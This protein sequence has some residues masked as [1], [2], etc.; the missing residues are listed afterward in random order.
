[1]LYSAIQACLPFANAEFTGTSREGQAVCY[2]SF[3]CSIEKQTGLSL[4][5]GGWGEVARSDSLIMVPNITEIHLDISK[6]KI[7][8]DN[9]L[10]FID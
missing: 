7:V 8:I 5:A 6:N 9:N 3:T 2:T 10:L 1:M 4:N